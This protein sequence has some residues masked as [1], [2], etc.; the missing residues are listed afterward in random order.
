MTID[1]QLDYLRKGTDEIIPEEDLRAKLKTGK[2]LRV[3]LG[4]D[5]TAPD[6]HL[7]HTVVIRKLRQFQQLGHDVIFLIGDFTGMIGDPS[8]RNTTRPRLS[9]R[10]I[11]KNAETYKEQIFKLLDKEKTIISFNSTWFDQFGA[12]DFIKLAARMTVKQILERK[13]FKDRLREEK[14][15][16]LHELLYPLVQGYDS[17]ELQADVELGGTDQKFN[18]LVGR[19]LQREEK[20]PQQVV[21]TMPLLLGTDGVKKMSKSLNNY[22]GINESA[23][24]MY[25]KVMMY[26]SD[27]LMWHYYELLTD[28][29]PHEIEDLQSACR[30]G[31]KNPRD[32]KSTLAKM[33]IKDFHSAEKA[34]EAEKNYRD[35]SI[36]GEIVG[37]VQQRKVRA[38]HTTVAQLLLES[39]LAKS[40]KEIAKN[41]QTKISLNKHPVD[42]LNVKE[43]PVE[44]KEGEHYRLQYGT[45]KVFELVG[46]NIEIEHHQVASDSIQSYGY[47]IEMMLLE[48]RFKDT[49]KLYEYYHVP[50]TAVEELKNAV[51]N[52]ESI[53]ALFN[54]KFRNIYSSYEIKDK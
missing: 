47:D 4:A 17:L 45:R 27:D 6:I 42:G 12:A 38:R 9:K 53:G 10:E 24:E 46:T 26:V 44:I 18:L 22:I 36:S 5:P 54:K 28:L 21:I 14:P 25:R 34:L 19:E 15:I 2:P 30:S 32:V 37:E 33:I 20:Q 40:L 39:G 41:S 49:G 23:D 11:Q 50:P 31:E 1:E 7:G 29:P 52:G 8:G 16:A 51:L 13:D 48:V 3:K 35:S 43:Y